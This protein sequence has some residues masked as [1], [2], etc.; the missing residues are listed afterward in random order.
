MEGRA[1]PFNTLT[2]TFCN[3]YLATREC[4]LTLSMIVGRKMLAMDCADSRNRTT[5]PSAAGFDSSTAITIP[6]PGISG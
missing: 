3:A 1:I 6:H 5:A 2:N 4:P